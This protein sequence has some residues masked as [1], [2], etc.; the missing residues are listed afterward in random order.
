MD[1]LFLW[2]SS[3]KDLFGHTPVGLFLGRKLIYFSVLYYGIGEIS[4]KVKISI[5]VGFLMV[6]CIILISL[7]EYHPEFQ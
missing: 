3:R 7:K 2:N 4:G 6:I 1:I 5:R